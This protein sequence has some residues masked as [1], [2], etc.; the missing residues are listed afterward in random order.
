MGWFFGFKLHLIVKDR[1]E[2]LNMKLTPG[3]VDDRVPVPELARDLF[4]KLV[5]DID[6]QIS[7][8]SLL[9]YDTFIDNWNDNLPFNP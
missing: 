2:I 4:G 8:K 5:A 1:G 7:A 9:Q 3:N 6:N